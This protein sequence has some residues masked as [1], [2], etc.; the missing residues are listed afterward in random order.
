[1]RAY[2]LYNLRTTQ[3]NKIIQLIRNVDYVV[4]GRYVHQN[5]FRFM[6]LKK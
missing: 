1:M 6:K 2:E 5:I 4:L 3:I